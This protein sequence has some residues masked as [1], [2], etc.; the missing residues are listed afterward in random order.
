MTSLTPGLACLTGRGQRPE[1]TGQCLDAIPVFPD[2]DSFVRWVALA[3][4]LLSSPS[5]SD[6]ID[7]SGNTVGG[8]VIA[9][10]LTEDPIAPRSALRART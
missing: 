10:R 2:L 4:R 1:E 8:G 9:P 6:L 7:V 5:T 3:A